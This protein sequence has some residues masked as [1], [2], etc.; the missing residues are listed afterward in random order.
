ME[1]VIQVWNIA[2]SQ[3]SIVYW[4][5]ANLLLVFIYIINMVK[6]SK[7]MKKYNSVVKRLGSSGTNLDTILKRYM[8]KVELIEQQNKEI[9]IYCNK[10][11][12]NILKCVQK[13]GVVRYNAF[14]DTGSELSFALALLDYENSGV[15]INGIYSRE[16]SNTYAKPIVKGTSSHNL[17]Q[18]ELQ[19][20]EKAKNSIEEYVLNINK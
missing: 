13:V 9:E 14:N 18:E 6:V 1:R 16:G 19:A 3:S 15:V 12:K 11:E 10:L 5:V 7:V 17:S 8:D 4:V 2:T 20:I